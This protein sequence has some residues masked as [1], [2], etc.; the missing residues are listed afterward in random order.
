V[1]ESHEY[2]P[3]EPIHSTR[4]VG[5]GTWGQEPWDGWG[6]WDVDQSDDEEGKNHSRPGGGQGEDQGEGEDE[7]EEDS[8]SDGEEAAS[9]ARMPIFMVR[10]GHRFKKRETHIL[11]GKRPWGD[12]LDV[13]APGGTGRRDVRVRVEPRSHDIPRT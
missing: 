3:V 11:D 5:V 9:S 12:F 4:N 2:D 8:G 10:E 6:D 7:D 13:D 1:Y